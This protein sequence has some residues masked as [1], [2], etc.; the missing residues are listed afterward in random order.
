MARVFK[1]LIIIQQAAVIISFAPESHFAT[2][3][4]LRCQGELGPGEKRSAGERRRRVSFQF[5]AYQLAARSSDRAQ[6]Q[7]ASPT[8]GL[9]RGFQYEPLDNAGRRSEPSSSS[10]GSDASSLKPPPRGSRERNPSYTSEADD[11]LYSPPSF[12]RSSS[13]TPNQ[14]RALLVVVAAVYG[15]NFGCVKLLQEALPP[16]MIMAARFS[17]ATALLIPLAVATRPN[18]SLMMPF[19]AGAETV[20]QRPSR[21]F[22]LLRPPTCAFVACPNILCVCVCVHVWKGLLGSPVS[23]SICLRISLT[24]SCVYCVYFI[25]SPYCGWAG[26]VVHLRFHSPGREPGN[27]ERGDKRLHLRVMRAFRALSRPA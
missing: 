16:S 7:P 19:L 5:P 12:L 17:I 14:A 24:L 21:G 27:H 23:I 26:L 6:P 25:L 8:G 13:V 18:K 10:A 15:T 2:P 11:P 1:S 9:Q 20:S 3:Y 22:M 4:S